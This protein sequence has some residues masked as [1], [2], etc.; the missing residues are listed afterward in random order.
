LG[1]GGDGVTAL[2]FKSQFA[3]PSPSA[4]AD[5]GEASLNFAPPS[6]FSLVDSVRDSNE[7]SRFAKA[8]PP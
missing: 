2:F 8:L 6:N 4:D 1:E 3:L 7:D 5:R